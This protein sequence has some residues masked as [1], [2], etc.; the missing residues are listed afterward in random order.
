MTPKNPMESFTPYLPTTFNVPEEND[1]IRTFLYDR[2][3]HIS[4]VVN[5]KVIGAFTQNTVSQNGK[6]YSYDTTK[7]VREGS[8]Y[9]IRIPSYPSAGVLNLSPPPNIN[10]QFVVFQVWGSAS[11]PP[12]TL[13]TGDYFSFYGSGNPKI[14]F[15]FS[16]TAIVVTTVG[17]G[18]GYS[19]FICVDFISDGS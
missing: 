17:L 19:G 14:T 12:T 1:R 7:K 18:T 13:G 5:D 3:A 4:D 10:Q 2:F 6:K 16:D 15:T 11:K 8:Q 9:L